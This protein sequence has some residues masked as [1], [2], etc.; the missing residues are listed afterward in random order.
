MQR[1]GAPRRCRFLPASSGRHLSYHC[2]VVDH[3]PLGNV[4]SGKRSAVS[5]HL[6]RLE[7]AVFP[8]QGDVALLR[9]YRCIEVPHRHGR[10]AEVDRADVC[11]RLRSFLFQ[12]GAH[13]TQSAKRFSVDCFRE[14]V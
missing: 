2:V 7:A 10:E 4:T 8:Q 6:C 12:E 13:G 14:S 1:R 9:K 11:L 5:Y 3:H